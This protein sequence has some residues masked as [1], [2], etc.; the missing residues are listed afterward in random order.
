MSFKKNSREEFQKDRGWLLASFPSD[1]LPPQAMSPLS[2][3][4]HEEG[5]SFRLPAV[6]LSTGFSQGVGRRPEAWRGGGNSPV[7]PA[8]AVPTAAAAFPVAPSPT[9]RF[10]RFRL[11]PGA[12]GSQAEVTPS[13]CRPVV[14]F[15]YFYSLSCPRSPVFGVLAPLE[16]L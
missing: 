1:L 12:P 3:V 8:L 13:P 16:C 11:P 2:P 7:S 4:I 9:G 14:P 10:V 5:G 15:C 6:W